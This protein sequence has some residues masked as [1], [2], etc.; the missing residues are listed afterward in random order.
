LSIRQ[1]LAGGW[2]HVEGEDAALSPA[3]SAMCPP[4]DGRR[5]RADSTEEEQGNRAA[6]Q[7]G[8]AAAGGSLDGY[9]HGL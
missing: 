9:R 1:I 5:R 2:A 7:A 8:E 6:F 3:L 4:S